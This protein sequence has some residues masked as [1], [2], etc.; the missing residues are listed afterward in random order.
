MSA[1]ALLLPRRQSRPPCRR[2]ACRPAGRQGTARGRRI[3]ALFNGQ[4]KE[5]SLTDLRQ[6]PARAYHIESNPLRHEGFFR[7]TQL[8][9]PPLITHNPQHKNFWSKRP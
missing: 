3:R 1:S 7:K 6:L 4:E 8:A 5:R 9:I 2:N